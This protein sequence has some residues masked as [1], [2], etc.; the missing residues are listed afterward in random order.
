MACLSMVIGVVLSFLA[1]FSNA[2][3]INPIHILPAC[4]RV[5]GSHLAFFRKFVTIQFE[6]KPGFALAS[7]RLSVTCMNAVIVSS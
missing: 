7:N 1:V 3:I 6:T 5:T 2:N 4:L